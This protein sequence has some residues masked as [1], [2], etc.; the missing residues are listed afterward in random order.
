MTLTCQEVL[1]HDLVAVWVHGSAALGGVGPASDLDV[2]VV[3]RDV[4]PDNLTTLGSALL[5]V[6]SRT[7]W[8]ELSV[9][10]EALARRPGPP[11]SYL[12]HVNSADRVAG[13]DPGHGDPDL[14]MHLLVA[15]SA[16]LATHGPDP[17]R[18]IGPI[19]QEWVLGYLRDELAW[20]LEH[21]DAR[22]AVLNACR[23]V[24]FAD[25]GLVLSKVD[26]VGWWQRRF[27]VTSHDAV[28]LD[29]VLTAQR[30][31]REL[32]PADDRARQF[33]DE[34]SRLLV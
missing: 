30:E 2:L 3:V 5:G 33:V 17:G 15:R 20:G 26:G 23:A 32:G 9:I 19:R 1:G 24:A 21:G 27:P 25:A 16:G 12:L 31:G 28:W 8:L 4:A 34:A 13:P 14:L 7:P 29:E 22:Y 10:R 6:G 11:W 18:V